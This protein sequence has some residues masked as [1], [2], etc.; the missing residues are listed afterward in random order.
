MGALYMLMVQLL[1]C[2]VPA[3]SLAS[4]GCDDDVLSDGAVSSAISANVFLF[5]LK[6]LET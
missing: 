2:A 6:I 1:Y 5:P 3:A 4:G